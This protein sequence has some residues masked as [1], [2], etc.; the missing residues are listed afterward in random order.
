MD[1]TTPV[2]EIIERFKLIEYLLNC[3]I[4]NHITPK[5][6]AFF[7]NIL[8][9]SSIINTGAKVKIIK[10]ICQ[11]KNKDYDF[12]NLHKLINIRN[13]FAH[14]DVCF[15][16]GDNSNVFTVAELKS[17]GVYIEEKFEKK[18]TE[19]KS[20]YLDEFKKINKLSEELSK[21]PQS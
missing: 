2:G 17:N 11:S 7:Q 13:L 21:C 9:N 15:G 5:D 12:T 8:L 20:I 14:E 3:M 19:F 16:V 1:Y 18:Y 10:Y 4:I 6:I